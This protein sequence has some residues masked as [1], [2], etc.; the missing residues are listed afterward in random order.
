MSTKSGPVP[1]P[2]NENELLSEA[3]TA[4]TSLQKVVKQD[5]ELDRTVSELRNYV[6]NARHSSHI[7]LE[8]SQLAAMFPIRNWLY[9]MPHAPY[10]L[11]RRDPGT[12]LV[13]AY[14]EMVKIAMQS[15][16]PT[17]DTPLAVNRRVDCLE[18]LCERFVS[19]TGAPAD[20]SIEQ[21]TSDLTASAQIAREHA[22][23]IQA[24]KQYIRLYR[25]KHGR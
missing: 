23:L 14:Y 17:I 12:M 5:K 6:Q 20:S 13:I 25:A 3:T 21:Q 7:K 19:D 11:A 15:L 9:W 1:A 2:A 18:L 10:R 24:P 8:D 22:N 16:C 4:L